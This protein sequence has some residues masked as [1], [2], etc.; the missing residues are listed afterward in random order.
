ALHNLNRLL[1]VYP[2]A[3]GVKTGTTPAAGQNL[4][5]AMRRDGRRIIVVVLGSSDRYADATA[6]LN[7]AVASDR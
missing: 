1:G 4:V 6:L 3:F 7:Y 5:A 2:G